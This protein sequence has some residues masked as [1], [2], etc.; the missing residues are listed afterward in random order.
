MLAFVPSVFARPAQ[1]RETEV[2]GSR[3]AGELDVIDEHDTAFLEESACIEEVDEHAFESVITV[4][5]G[6]IE[7]S[8]LSK[9]AGKRYLRFLSM[10]LDQIAHA[11]ILEDLKSYARIDGPMHRKGL[12]LI[13][14]RRDVPA[15][16][17]VQEQSLAD[18]ERRDREA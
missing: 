1:V 2:H 16:G 14:I 7:A 11:S 10:E 12:E 9:Q 8:L 5:E 3:Y 15:L 6:E 4:Q 18:E 13:R 17:S